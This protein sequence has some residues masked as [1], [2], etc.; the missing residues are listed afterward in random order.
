MRTVWILSDCE[1]LPCDDNP[2]LMRDGQLAEYLSENGWNVVWWAPSFNHGTKK[3]R[4]SNTTEIRIN[5]YEKLVALH[6]PIIYR[7]NTSVKR[8]F[9]YK[10]LVKELRKS[11]K[12]N[13]NPDIILCSWPT[14]SFAK[15]ALK[16]GAENDVPV[17][18][19]VR[20][21]WPDIFTRAFPDKVKGIGSIA[22]APLKNQAKRLLRKADSI[23]SVTPAGLNW[24]LEKAG[25]KKRSTDR[26]IYIGYKDQQLDETENHVFE[27]WDKL[28]VN[29]GTW[30]IT[31]FGTFSDSTLDMV[32]CIKAFRKFSERHK[33]ARLILC[34]AGDAEEKFK[35]AAGGNEQIIFPGWCSN[36]QIKSVLSISDV[37]LYPF[38]NLEDFKDAF[39][40]KIIGYMA[41]SLPVMTSLEG[42]PKEYINKYGFGEIYLEGSVESCEETLELFYSDENK[43]SIMGRRAR[44]RYEKDFSTSVV[45]NQF[46]ELFN[47]LINPSGE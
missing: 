6:S 25:R 21:L 46:T 10:C 13:K 7:K 15:V 40:N 26:V 14:Q 16:Y 32:T 9:F 12:E 38:K 28:S 29:S 19:D 23:V 41:A 5:Q 47:S 11:F 22:L 37:G 3:D 18:L 30:N 39:G 33:E 4:F 42:F 8:V 24:G 17:V 36:E 44:E 34:G 31:Y 1:P 27:E 2:R 20:D 43:K 45:N 35:A